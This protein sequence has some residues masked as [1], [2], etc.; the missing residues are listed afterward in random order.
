V[1]DSTAGRQVLDAQVVVIAK[2]PKPG[3]VKTR[4]S[5]PLTEA[6]AA[7][8]A[9]ASL[10]DTLGAVRDTAVRARVLALEGR[11]GAWVPGGI[12]VVPQRRGPFGERLAG[13]IED[14]WALAPWP[15]LLVGM[16]TPQVRATDLEH[17]A[18]TLFTPGIDTV[19]GPAED[20][21]YWLLGTRRPVQ[22]MFA[23]IP[24]S[25]A[26]TAAAQLRRFE[27]LGLS[28]AFVPALRDV[29][30]I[31]DATAVADLAPGSAFAKA[32]RAC[33]TRESSPA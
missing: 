19:L 13:A 8:V 26:Q 24:M 17:A 3:Q 16:D 4:L 32:L 14:A 1:S 11:P 20:G 33:T 30:T 15:V 12:T 23:G 7:T 6:E 27:A 2:E 18:R 21:G 9:Q 22:T 29:D 10:I 5:P 28:C 31:F 25:T